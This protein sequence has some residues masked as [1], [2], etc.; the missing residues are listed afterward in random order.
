MRKLA[1]LAALCLA[2][3][4]S[5]LDREAQATL[6][7]TDGLLAAVTTSAQGVA[8]ILSEVRAE[9][10][11]DLED[12]RAVSRSVAAMSSSAAT[13]MGHVA[14]ISSSIDSLLAREAAKAPAIERLGGEIGLALLAL[15]VV[16]CAVGVVAFVRGVRRE[17]RSGLEQHARALERLASGPP[18]AS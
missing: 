3:G 11:A 5:S 14:S 17:L 10:R 4:C 2:I 1:A 6:R 7:Q 18:G 8:D 9:Y 16:L 15:L 13:A 12:R